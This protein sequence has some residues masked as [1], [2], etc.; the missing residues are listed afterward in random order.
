MWTLNAVFAT[1]GLV[2]V[3]TLALALTAALRSEKKDVDKKTYLAFLFPLLA[4][5]TIVICA[6]H[7]T[8]MPILFFGH[9]AAMC[10]CWCLMT[11]GSLLYKASGAFE[12]TAGLR[13]KARRGHALSQ[14][15]ACVAAVVGYACIFENHRIMGQSQFGF[16]K[17]NPILKTVHALL[18]YPLMIWLLLQGCQGW[19]KY[20]NLSRFL[21]HKSAGRALVLFAGVNIGIVLF[22]VGVPLGLRRIMQTGFLACSG[23]AF[24]LLGSM[25]KAGARELPELAE[26]L[27]E[28][29]LYERCPPP[30][31]VE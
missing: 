15:L 9:I 5:V 13:Q 17:G 25:G 11:S 8:A 14:T 20:S 16:D 18:G 31:Q 21:Y 6:N 27:E 12:L 30:V 28:P 26:P 19:L 7:F 2:A 22:A 29:I 24:Y 1:A 10:I 4:A 23:G 3:V